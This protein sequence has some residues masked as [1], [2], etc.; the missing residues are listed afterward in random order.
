MTYLSVENEICLMTYLSTQNDS[1]LMTYL[2]TE[3]DSGLMTYM[4]SDISVHKN[5]SGLMTYLTTENAC[6]R[7]T[8][9]YFNKASG[10]RTDLTSDLLVRG[11]I[12]RQR[13]FS[14]WTYLSSEKTR[15]G[16]LLATPDG[17]RPL[18]PP[19]NESYRTQTGGRRAGRVGKL[20]RHVIARRSLP[21]VFG[22][23]IK[24]ILRETLVRVKGI[25]DKP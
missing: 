9:Q 12:R 8:D 4:S 21:P 25:R 5:D 13:T 19:L 14:Q 15:V 17:R 6:G 10:Q 2:S 22:I 3:N 16:G 20:A 18:P 7:R 11:R 1:G 23:R 24:F